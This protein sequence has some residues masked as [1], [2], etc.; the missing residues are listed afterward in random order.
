MVR[1]WASVR[2]GSL[3]RLVE[4]TMGRAETLLLWNMFRATTMGVSG[5]AWWW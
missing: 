3:H 5:E 4:S 2:G 1:L